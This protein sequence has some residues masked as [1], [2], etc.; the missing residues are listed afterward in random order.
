MW[1]PS[2]TIAH[3]H[4][5]SVGL[6]TCWN[7]PNQFL[8]QPPLPG[9]TFHP[10]TI[11]CLPYSPLEHQFDKTKSPIYKPGCHASKLQHFMNN[12]SKISHTKECERFFTEEK[13]FTIYSIYS[14]HTIHNI[15]SSANDQNVIDIMYM[16]LGARTFT[17]ITVVLSLHFCGT[18]QNLGLLFTPKIF[19][20]MC[21]NI[22][23]WFAGYLKNTVKA[24]QH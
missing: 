9:L 12:P 17:G 15:Q 24:I 10:Q 5:P 23:C 11:L 2:P 18:C 6:D 16:H 22:S 13:Y 4:N 8:V 14:T 3:Q 20:C 19:L 1:S 7:F 21:T